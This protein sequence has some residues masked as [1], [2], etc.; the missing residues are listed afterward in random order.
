MVGD[1]VQ[2]R[3]G[4]PQSYLLL[5]IVGGGFIKPSLVI[6]TFE[7]ALLGL[8]DHWQPG[9]NCDHPPP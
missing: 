8:K 4:Q 1:E 7:T 5:L 9:C 2:P 6:A 3:C